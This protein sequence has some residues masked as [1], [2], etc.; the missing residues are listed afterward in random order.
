VNESPNAQ[1][2]GGNT[3]LIVGA[4]VSSRDCIHVLLKHGAGV[5]FANG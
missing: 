2:G 5:D 3:P 4:R 1:D